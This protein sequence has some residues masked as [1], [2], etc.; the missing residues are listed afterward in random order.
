M[1]NSRRARWAMAAVLVGALSGAVSAAQLDGPATI[2]YDTYRVPTIV[3][4]T[5]HDAPTAVPGVVDLVDVPGGHWWRLS[6]GKQE[7]QPVVRRTPR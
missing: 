7:P 1:M 2:Y 6:E 3:A 5:E 4:G